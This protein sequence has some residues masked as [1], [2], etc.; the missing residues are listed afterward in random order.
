MGII[1]LKGAVNIVRSFNEIM[2]TAFKDALER[3]PILLKRKSIK[4]MLIKRI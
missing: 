4:S 3:I 1:I 2:D